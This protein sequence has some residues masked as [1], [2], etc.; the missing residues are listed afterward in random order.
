MVFGRHIYSYYYGREW[1]P[2]NIQYYRV[3]QRHLY[4]VYYRVLGRH[5]YSLYYRQ[6]WTLLYRM[7]QNYCRGFRGL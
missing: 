5:R 1:K 2:L 4:S 7:I 3:L 6:E